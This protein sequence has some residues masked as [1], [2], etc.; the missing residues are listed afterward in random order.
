MRMNKCV[1]YLAWLTDNADACETPQEALT[2]L[3]EYMRGEPAFN[4]PVRDNTAAGANGWLRSW[5]R[6]PGTYHY[7]AAGGFKKFREFKYHMRRGTLVTDI[8]ERMQ[9]VIRET[10]TDLPNSPNGE[11]SFDIPS[12]LKKEAEYD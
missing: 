10:L 9:E 3:A 12:R 6:T 2:A 11:Y 1:E 7:R 8:P 5:G 4:D